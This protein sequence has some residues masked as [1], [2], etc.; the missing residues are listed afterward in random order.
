MSFSSKI[1]SEKTESEL[2]GRYS[3]KRKPTHLSVADLFSKDVN[4]KKMGYGYRAQN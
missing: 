3:R 4:A 2:N 1:D